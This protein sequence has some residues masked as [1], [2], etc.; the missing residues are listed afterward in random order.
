MLLMAAS[1]LLDVGDF[2]LP[3]RVAGNRGLGVSGELG[4]A[5]LVL[6]R[7]DP[8]FYTGEG[9]LHRQGHPRGGVPLRAT[10]TLIRRAT[11]CGASR[12]K[13]NRRNRP[14]QA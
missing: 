13:S 2:R 9:F 8:T 6:L 12:S 1:R 11:P 7:T 3:E 4:A 10:G 14:E 5:G